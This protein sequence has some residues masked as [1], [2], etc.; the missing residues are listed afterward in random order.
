MTEKTTPLFS[1]GIVADPQYADIDPRPEMG[2]HY[3][4]SPKKLAEAV[5]AFCL[6][7]HLT[8]P[9]TPYV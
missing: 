9:T 4:E 2:R 3:R 7:T 1:F 5:D 8:L 6:Y